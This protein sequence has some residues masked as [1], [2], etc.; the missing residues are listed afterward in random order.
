MP[1]TLPSHLAAV[2]P[3]KLWRPRWFDGVALSSGAVAP[4]VGHLMYRADGPGFP[5]THTWPALIWWCLPVALAYAWIFRSSIGTV[6]AHLPQN[7]R[8]GWGVDGSPAGGGHRSWVTV[9]SALLGAASHLAWDWLTHTD[10]WLVVVFG[11]RWASVTDVAWWTVSDLTS[12]VLGA[13]VAIWC[14][15]RLGRPDV[16]GADRPERAT[17]PGAFWGVVI[18]VAA[19]GLVTVPMLPGA[20][21]PAATGVRLIHLVGAALLAGV[22]AVR[23]WPTRPTR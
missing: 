15:A 23:C 16:R 6:A 18:V 9:T 1:L 14:L 4:D 13:V 8:F 22:L 10:D 7:R 2:L 11:V 5:D 12:T 19:V 20:S 17:R 3:L 21:F